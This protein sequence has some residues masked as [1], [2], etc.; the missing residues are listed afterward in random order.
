[1]RVRSML[2]LRVALNLRQNEPAQECE[3]VGTSLNALFHGHIERT[4][5]GCSTSGNY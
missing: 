5:C 2:K 4:C 3:Q 1:M